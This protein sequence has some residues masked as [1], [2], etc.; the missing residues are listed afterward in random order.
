MFST[1]FFSGVIFQGQQSLGPEAPG[2][3]PSGPSRYAAASAPQPVC[4]VCVSVCMGVLRVSLC[5]YVSVCVYVCGC[6][7]QDRASPYNSGAG[8]AFSNP[9][10]PTTSVWGCGDR[11]PRDMA[12]LRSHHSP[13]VKEEVARDSEAVLPAPQHWPLSLGGGHS[14]WRKMAPLACPA[15]AL[16][17]DRPRAL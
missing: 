11:G 3:D 4:G 2:G 10:N 15:L 16:T 8:R 13:E 6:P 1:L 5:T 17:A 7:S 9:L 12:C 14:R